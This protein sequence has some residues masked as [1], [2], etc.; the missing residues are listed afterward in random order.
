MRKLSSGLALSGVAV[1]A[2]L[3]VAFSA[4][5][6]VDEGHVGIVKHFGEATSMTHP[7]IH[8]K[9]PFVDEIVSMETRT[10]KNVE[11]HPA[12]TKEQM[13]VTAKVSVNWTVNKSEVLDLYRQYGGLEQ[14]EHRILD[15]RLRAAAKDAIAHFTAEELIQNR[16]ATIA[17]AEQRLKASMSDFPVTLDSLQIENIVLPAG[18]LKSIETKQTEKNLAKAEEHKLARQKF[19]AD[20]AINTANAE[21]DATRARADGEAYRIKLLAEAEATAIEKKAKALSTNKLLIEYERVKRWNGVLPST[22]LGS[23]TNTLL[24]LK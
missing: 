17:L 24:S 5:Y 7:G 9:V 19:T 22:M 23:D 3:S 2:L 10:R 21:R 8:M 15:P 13:P 11:D 16:T 20:Q 1:V 12:A 4:V 6:T 18:Y 14:F